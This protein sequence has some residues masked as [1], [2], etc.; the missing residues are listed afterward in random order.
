MTPE[1][2]IEEQN[3][4]AIAGVSSALLVDVCS[5][6]YYLAYGRMDSYKREKDSVRLGNRIA[7]ETAFFVRSALSIFNLGMCV[8]CFDSAYN[9]R[10]TL[11]TEYKSNR[12]KKP[13]PDAERFV[14]DCV[15]DAAKVLR[16]N[17]RRLGFQTTMAYG[18][19]ADDCM[20]V[21][22]EY[23]APRLRRIIMLTS[24]E[25]MYQCVKDNV[26]VARPKGKDLI[27]VA[28]VIKDYGV[29]PDQ[30][31]EH[32]ALAGC[33]SDDVPGVA[34][35]G[36]G[37]ATEWLN[38]RPITPRR[39]ALI[40]AADL[41]LW[42]L[43]TKLPLVHASH[44]PPF[45]CYDPAVTLVKYNGWVEQFARDAGVNEDDFVSLSDDAET[46]PEPE[47]LIR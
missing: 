29:R 45:V 15:K 47:D 9:I 4:L 25:D 1:Q 13:L 31:A 27:D 8:L 6:I 44:P 37:T 46:I 18:Y 32:K 43:L 20:A 30:I 2:R 19:E 3:R 17:A 5:V 28:G 11:Y 39:K 16:Q 26:F 41:S 33:N 40:E 10:K 24:D 22:V 36:K 35:I 42:R 21:N 12:K 23:L 34:G 14:I 38:G 7:A